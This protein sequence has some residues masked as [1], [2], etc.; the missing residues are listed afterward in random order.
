MAFCTNCGSQVPDGSRFCE[1]C[2]AKLEPILTQ[3]PAVEPEPT[4]APE[5]V[6]QSDQAPTQPTQQSQSW[7]QSAAPP[8]YNQT[9]PEQPAYAPPEQ[10]AYTQPEQ[11]L[12]TT[13]EQPAY[14]P[15]AQPAY[16]P[17]EQTAYTPPE[18]PAYAQQPARATNAP[19]PQQWDRQA[20]QPLYSQQPQQAAYSQQ[21]QQT[22]YPQQAQQQWNQPGYAPQPQQYAPA[23]T[24][25]KKKSKKPLIIG[26]IAAAVVAIA[27][28]VIVLVGLGKK[29]KTP[30][31]LEGAG[32]YSLTR[33]ESDGQ[34]FNAADLGRLGMDGAFLE[35]IEDGTGSMKLAADEVVS[36]T[37]DATTITAQGDTVGY[38]RT[39]D[40]I[41]LDLDGVVCTF[42]TQPPVLPASQS[43]AAA[44]SEPEPE[45]E[46]EPQ[47]EPPLLEAG[48]YV[49]TSVEYEGRVYT[50]AELEDFGLAGMYF[51]IQSEGTG[52]VF[53]SD[54]TRE[55]VTWT[56]QTITV[57]GDVMEFDPMENRF[58]ILSDGM[59]MCFE[60]G[61][62]T[63]L[64]V[65]QGGEEP[66]PNGEP[67]PDAPG[68]LLDDLD[69][70]VYFVMVGMSN[71][72]E[73][74]DYDQLIESGTFI[75]CVLNPDGTGEFHNEATAEVMEIT[76]T[77]SEFISEGEGQP[78]TL[79]GDMLYLEAEGYT[80]EF[81]YSQT[82]PEIP[83]EILA[84]QGPGTELILG[85]GVTLDGLEWLVETYCYFTAPNAGDYVIWTEGDADTYV[86]T[87]S[88][89]A[90][91]DFQDYADD[92]GSD[93]N[94]RLEVT[95]S[96][97]ESIYLGVSTYSDGAV[98]TRVFVDT[99]ANAPAALENYIESEGNITIPSDWFGAMRL[100]NFDD[101][102]ADV[103]V[104]VYGIF[105]Y[106]SGVPFLEIYLADDPTT[107]LYINPGSDDDAFPILSMWI[108]ED[109]TY[110]IPDIGDDDA[111]L[112]DTY[113]DVSEADLV[114]S[115][116]E[117]GSLYFSAPAFWN[118]TYEAACDVELFLRETY[119]SWDL[120]SDP[121]IPPGLNDYLAAVG[122]N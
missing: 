77:D 63:Q 30:E 41:V 111:W 60:Q 68:G 11:P 99:P 43:A 21:S 55:T 73:H 114:S 118:Y 61:D 79:E 24:G 16:T 23:Q 88:N 82:E 4:Y 95:L 81:Q 64:A 72:E 109:P 57:S 17:P 15:P 54:G 48:E 20:T 78:Y 12:Y 40:I 110:V 50:G 36:L 87:Y 105:R 98:S 28:L 26:I 104:D 86:Y 49:L 91:E 70:P 76:W 52:E 58:T 39:G 89:P 9:P 100:T 108:V 45:P 106:S 2:G 65:V 31:T 46:P 3:T 102:S 80:G 47:P 117:N 53:E 51:L 113:L 115:Q 22:A 37:W 107:Y 7:E 90:H 19:P 69:G 74:A 29:D 10:S 8:V 85:S 1:N 103:L 121:I 120:T 59:L 6:Q 25:G 92:N 62:H 34:V 13:P 75:Y 56:G 33:V 42:S 14:V 122:L 71:G 66:A 67:E 18:Q 97:G 5:P 35:L 38:T 93:L 83:E 27:A 32:Y 44:Q 116:V 112:L 96:A 84:R 119:T 101:G 94:F